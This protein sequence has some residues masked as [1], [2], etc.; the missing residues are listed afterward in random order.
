MQIKIKE[1]N[2][3]ADAAIEARDSFK[4]AQRNLLASIAEVIESN[5]T[6]E[7]RPNKKW[8]DNLNN[9]ETRDQAMS[10]ALNEEGTALDYRM[11]DC[12][13]SQGFIKKMEIEDDA[14]IFTLEDIDS[15]KEVRVSGDDVIDFV[16]VVEFLELCTA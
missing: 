15:G 8:H 5:G 10:D 4:A 9:P 12:R 13:P 2:E 1:L 7:F 16:P 6:V 11:E 3:K 14:V